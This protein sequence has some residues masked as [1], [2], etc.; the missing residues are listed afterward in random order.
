MIAPI[1]AKGPAPSNA[2]FAAEQLCD[3]TLYAKYMGVGSVVVVMNGFTQ[4]ICL[5]IQPG[6]EAAGWVVVLAQD[7]QL[8][9]TMTFTAV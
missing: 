1:Q 3:T 9:W 2:Y 4:K 5:E 8:V 7:P 6:Y